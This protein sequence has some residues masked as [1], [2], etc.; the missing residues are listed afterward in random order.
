MVAL[1]LATNSVWAQT[2][3]PTTR[4][5]DDIPVGWTVTAG[6]VEVPVTPYYDGSPLGSAIIPEDAT[7]LLTPPDSLKPRVK[8]V[9]LLLPEQIPLTFEAK[10]A[11][12][13]V[14]FGRYYPDWPQPA[15]V[16][17]EYSKNGGEWTTYT[18][19]ITL[20]NVGDK[21]SFRGDNTK[22]NP[23]MF[24][25]SDTCYIY[26]NIMSLINKD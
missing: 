20:D 4:V 1:V 26:G 2:P 10:T 3:T 7:V 16:T 5:L 17:I 21:V 25:C 24:Y 8:D 22:Y 15:T 6:G 11:G 13:V 19:S 14:S 18:S 9:E 23:N 12:A